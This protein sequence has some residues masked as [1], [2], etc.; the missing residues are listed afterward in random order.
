MQIETIPPREWQA[1][2]FGEYRS[3]ISNR[4][5]KYGPT[6]KA[7]DFCTIAEIQKWVKA[8]RFKKAESLPLKQ[9]TT[10]ISAFGYETRR[11]HNW[12]S[13]SGEPSRFLYF[14]IIPEKKD[15][16]VVINNEEIWVFAKTGELLQSVNYQDYQK[17]GI[18]EK[19][20]HLE[21]GN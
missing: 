10:T 6:E 13:A 2:Y 20:G 12:S 14:S 3:V 7:K 11:E 21:L 16:M 15:L 17:M 9:G 5:E 19:G 4:L 1:V 8:G 18:V